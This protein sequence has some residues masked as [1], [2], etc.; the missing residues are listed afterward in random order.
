MMVFVVLAALVAAGG[1]FAQEEEEKAEKNWTNKTELGFTATSGNA[2]VTNFSFGNEYRHNWEKAEL[3]FDVRL[4]KNEST[5]KFYSGSS[6]AP[7][8]EERTDTTAETYFVGL[9]YRRTI[10]GRLFWYAD[11]HWFRNEPAGLLDR[12]RGGVGIGYLIVDGARHTLAGTVGATFTDDT[13]AVAGAPG[14]EVS[15]SYTSAT[16][17]LDY[18][19]KI[20]DSAELTSVANWF[21]DIDE[22]DNWQ[23]NWITA[24]TASLSSQL[25]LRVSYSLV[26]DNLP[27]SNLIPPGPGATTTDSVLVEA[28]KQDNFLTASLVLNF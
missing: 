27:G 28:D 15:D 16:A 25:A 18:K 14:G 22:S 2:E 24:V 12:Y 7:V 9:G 17:Q 4:I 5:V 21:Q 19:F 23:A 8:F 11:G 26:Y 6:A 13:K 3:S 1:A 20:S 10:T